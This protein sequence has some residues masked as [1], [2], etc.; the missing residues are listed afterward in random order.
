MASILYHISITLYGIRDTMEAFK[1][2]AGTQPGRTLP[3]RPSKRF[4]P[5]YSLEIT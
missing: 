4:Q 5:P 3:Y 1:D 2:L